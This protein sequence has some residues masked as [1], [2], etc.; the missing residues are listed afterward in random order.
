MIQTLVLVAAL[1]NL[2]AVEGRVVQ[3]SVVSV[4]IVNSTSGKVVP[5]HLE[6]YFADVFNAGGKTEIPISRIHIGSIV[7][8]FFDA[9]FTG[10]RRAERIELL[11]Q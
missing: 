9:K 2:T 3:L 7:K 5:F 10:T 8:V 1:S 11:R 6:P 4:S